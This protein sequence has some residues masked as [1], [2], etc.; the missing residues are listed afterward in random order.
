[1]AET[2]YG[3]G[4][5]D[6]QSNK[7][8]EILKHAG[9]EKKFL[10]SRFK[11]YANE[12]NN[13]CNSL[14]SCS[15]AETVDALCCLIEDYDDDLLDDDDFNKK[16]SLFTRE[17]H[18]NK[19]EIDAEVTAE[20]VAWY[21]TNDEYLFETTQ[22][23]HLKVVNG[24]GVCRYLPEAVLEI[25]AGPNSLKEVYECEKLH[26][27]YLLTLSVESGR[28]ILLQDIKKEVWRE[29][30]IFMV[31][32]KL[33]EFETELQLARF[34]HE[35]GGTLYSKE[36]VLRINESGDGIWHES[37]ERRCC[38]PPYVNKISV[39]FYQMADY[40]I[41]NK[42]DKRRKLVKY[43]LQ[44]GIPIISEK[45]FLEMSK[46]KEQEKLPRKFQ[47]GDKVKLGKFSLNNCENKTELVWNVVT[48]ENDRALLLLDGVLPGKY[49][50]LKTLVNLHFSEEEMK[51]ITEEGLFLPTEQELRKLCRGKN[52]RIARPIN[53]AI[54]KH[55]NGLCTRR[56]YD[57][58]GEE[59][60]YIGSDYYCDEGKALCRYP[61]QELANHRFS[62][63]YKTS[64]MHNNG[65]MGWWLHGKKKEDRK[66]VDIAGS[67]LNVT[68]IGKE[69][70]IGLRPM[71]WIKNIF[72]FRV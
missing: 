17:L 26:D 34:I 15:V 68:G 49:E 45:E 21:V 40:L 66:Y 39:P 41:C 61:G 6:I 8:D 55:M 67:I 42:L 54:C 69:K 25:G 16:L 13:L 36:R 23:V 27:E 56:D 1:M 50:E 47:V 72:E 14:L 38:E 7:L 20:I 3:F 65:N 4:Y 19:E 44:Y 64:V 5:I 48:V 30:L 12:C 43:A 29:D 71:M 11:E 33:E 28:G 60:P 57:W 62:S 37:R 46:C 70:W 10:Y 63:F 32:G 51:F 18:E 31:C 24:K 52:E 35:N 2:Y 9:V 59:P 58:K 53:C 22:Y